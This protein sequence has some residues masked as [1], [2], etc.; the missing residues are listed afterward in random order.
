[1]RPDVPDRPDLAAMVASQ[2]GARGIRDARVLDAMRRVPRHEFVLDHDRPRAGEDTP[3]AI[4]WGQTISQPYIVALMTEILDIGPGCRVLELGT[5]SGYQAAILAELASEVYT[6]E[7][8]PE[9]ADRARTTL[10]R[11]GYRNVRYRLGDGGAGWPE[12]APFDRVILTAAPADVPPRLIDQLA[13]GGVLVAPVGHDAQVLT[14]LRRTPTGLER[15]EI[16]PVRFVPL[17]R[18]GAG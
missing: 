13:A 2:I 4:G 18:A 5:G 8:V 1:V 6:I 12:A 9:L 3:L 7:I 16:L 11:L 17:V 14:V 15:H 10:D